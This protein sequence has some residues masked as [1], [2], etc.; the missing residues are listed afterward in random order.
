[1]S[2]HSVPHELHV[3][4]TGLRMVEGDLVMESAEVDAVGRIQ[5]KCAINGWDGELA[6]GL[7]LE[8]AIRVFSLLPRSLILMF[9]S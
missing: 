6:Q 1:M 3:Q 9:Q 7:S 8:A 2:F 5:M 4:Q